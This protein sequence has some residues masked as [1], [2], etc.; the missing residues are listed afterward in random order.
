VKA[1]YDSNVGR[2]SKSSAKLPAISK[3]NTRAAAARLAAGDEPG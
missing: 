2:P 1:S 3:V